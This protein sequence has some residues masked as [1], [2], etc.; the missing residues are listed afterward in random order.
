[1][2]DIIKTEAVVLS[3][4]NYGDTSCIASL[5][6]E[7]SGKMSVIIKG[8][9]NPKSKFGN[10]IDPLNHI[11]IVFY[12]KEN[13]DLHLLSEADNVS[14]FPRIRE[15]LEVLKFAFSVIEL[16]Q[17][18]SPD[19]EVNTKVFKGLVRILSLFNSSNEHPGITFG[20]F[21]L[22]Y[23]AEIGYRLELNKCSNCERTDMNNMII[24]YNNE[25]GI[26]CDKCKDEYMNYYEISRELF[27]YLNCLTHNDTI[28]NV[29]ESVIVNAIDFFETYLKSHI[30]D[31]KGIQSLRSF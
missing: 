6:T 29:K 2:S 31:F 20:R 19:D 30:P 23:I 13:R 21:F 8:A 26:L 27:S 18:L 12:K 11:Q 14:H 15:N 17:N 28:E 3:K 7:N 22:F 25:N 4:I 1:M 16:V 24:G 9:R 10:I 5:F